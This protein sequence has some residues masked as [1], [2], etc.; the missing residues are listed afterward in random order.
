MLLKEVLTHPPFDRLT[1][2]AGKEGLRNEVSHATTMDAPD[3]LPYLKTNDILVTT[4]YHLKD[5]PHKLT[6][7]IRHMA[8]QGCSSLWI[9]TKRF[10]H[11]LPPEALILADELHFP[12]IE[13]SNEQSLGD[14]V[15]QIL[16]IILDK[17]TNELR[18][19]IDMHKIFSAHILSGEGLNACVEHLSELIG[20]TTYLTTP[21]LT[22]LKGQKNCGALPAPLYDWETQGGHLLLPK[23]TSTSFSILETKN[24]ITLF[25][26]VSHDK[27]MALLVI[28]GPVQSSERVKLLAIEQ[29]L[30]VISF[31]LLREDAVKQYTRRMRNEFFLHFIDR[32]FSNDEETIS[33]AKEFDLPFKQ[34]YICAAGWFD[35]SEEGWKRSASPDQMDTLHDFF[36]K[37][38]LPFG[39]PCHLFTKG[40]SII[41]LIEIEEAVKD[42]QAFSSS[43]LEKLQIGIKRKYGRTISF[44]V[45]HI[46]HNVLFVPQG[47]KEARDSLDTNKLT[48]GPSSISF[49]RSKD[50]NELLRLLPAKDLTDFYHN[51]IQQLKLDN[52]DE[53][54][55]L[56]QTLFVYME[57]HCQISETAKRL[58][59]HRNTVVYRLEKC[60]ELLGIPIKD[61]DFTLQIRLALRMKNVLKL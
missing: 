61:P 52:L 36:E 32:G 8:M 6:E 11:E 27:K 29:A 42:V 38:L 19:A 4:G 46:C 45:S 30:N 48:S 16:S 44:G 58:F 23:T 7:L 59:V 43:L 51:T 31:E 13:M 18:Y 47:F 35:F 5:Q 17:K 22:P 40:D 55:T 39:A 9:K 60:E 50:V 15:N 1:I 53:E 41:L 20:H 14:T 57:T 24:E 21:Y 33:R 12:I 26:V 25:P 3:I 34:K 37:S 54:Q 28:L 2:L 10:L 49:Y 56:L